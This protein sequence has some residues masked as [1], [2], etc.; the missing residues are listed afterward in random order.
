MITV[1]DLL[2]AAKGTPTYERQAG[3]SRWTYWKL[4]GFGKDGEGCDPAAKLTVR[5]TRTA[6]YT[7]RLSLTRIRYVPRVLF[8]EP[9]GGVPIIV[10][11]LLAHPPDPAVRATLHH[12]PDRFDAFYRTA[13]ATLQRGD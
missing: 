1:D 11:H 5:W 2:V 13:L 3:H 12:H 8:S 6:G 4:A 10:E 7:A 9:L